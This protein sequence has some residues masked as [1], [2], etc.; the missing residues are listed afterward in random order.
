LKVLVYG[1][2]SKNN[3]GDSLFA[4]AFKF[5][6]PQLD[7]IFTDAITRSQLELVSTVFIGGGSFLDTDLVI[8]EDAFAIL[9]TKNIFY[10]GV[11]AETLIC[12]QHIELLVVAKLIAIR[13]PKYIDKIKNINQNTIVIP[14]LIYALP[15]HKQSE[16]E[17]KS[18]LI[19]PNAHIVPKW[20]DEHY[21][22]AAY[23]VFRSEFAQFL[24][25]LIEDG[26]KINFFS[27]CDSKLIDDGWATAG[28]ISSMKYVDNSFNLGQKCV[29]IDAITKLFSK[30]QFI[31]SARYHGAILADLLQIKHFTIAH[32]NK[33]KNTYT[34]PYYG[35]SK[36]F[37]LDQFYSISN[38]PYSCIP[39]ESNFDDLL[40]KMD[41]ILCDMPE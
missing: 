27:M 5:L 37:L 6:F 2:Y 19:L 7:F 22:H 12:S 32:H 35:L 41:E 26:F 24:D 4:E 23:D 1:F 28:I 38:E 10:I 17:H 34:V 30:Y 36:Q 21:K 33:L 39:L 15:K 13:T 9:K 20:F 11:G 40:I 18:I 31:I 25:I 14:D 8:T 16:K 29:D 3:I